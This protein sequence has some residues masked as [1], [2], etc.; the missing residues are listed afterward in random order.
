MNTF[1]TLTRTPSNGINDKILF[2][3]PIDI[4]DLQ[5]STNPSQSPNTWDT[6]EDIRLEDYSFDFLD[7]DVFGDI[8]IS[9]NNTYQKS[10]TVYPVSDQTQSNNVQQSS[11]YPSESP[12]KSNL[13]SVRSKPIEIVSPPRTEFRPRTERE[14]RDS[15]HFLRCD[16]TSK[17]E[18]PTIKL[19]SD[20]HPGQNI[21]KVTLVKVDHQ[22][23]VYTLENKER[24][25]SSFIFKTDE[26]HTLYFHLTKE[27]CEKGEKTLHIEFIKGKQVGEITKEKI[28]KE[29]LNLS[30][31]SFTC[32]HRLPN[33]SY[34][35]DE[36]T[37]AYS[38]TMAEKYGEFKILDVFQKYG[39]MCGNQKVCIETKG[40]LPKDYKQNLV[41]KIQDNG[42]ESSIPIEK[43]QKNGNNFT[44]LMPKYPDPFCERATV[45]ITIEY[46]QDVIYEDDYTYLRILDRAFVNDQTDGYVAP[47]TITGQLQHDD[48]EVFD[49]FTDSPATSL[50]A[51]R[52]RRS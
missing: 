22:P 2:A 45:R 3:N 27:D 51:K 34:V 52:L 5:K 42:H 16:K 43:M 50:P 11:G 6:I 48:S 28:S 30:K 18:H 10:D 26:P 7:G 20:W 25:T 35:A 29:Q 14:S 37:T 36:A 15:S 4:L 8:E 32:M 13:N 31:L 49:F 44:F 33:G 9:P 46:E 17:H 21:I 40:P 47:N 1:A 38:D 41:L 23:H 12:L 39:P 24:K 19:Q